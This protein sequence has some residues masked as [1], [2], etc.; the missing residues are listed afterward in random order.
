MVNSHVYVDIGEMW[1]FLLMRQNIYECRMPDMNVSALEWLSSLRKTCLEV[2]CPE[3][4]HLEIMAVTPYEERQTHCFPVL[5][6]SNGK[7]TNLTQAC[8]RG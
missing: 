4:S 7:K 2:M 3:K 1:Y 6:I 5:Q 8:V